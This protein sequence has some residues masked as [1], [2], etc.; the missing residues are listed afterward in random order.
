MRVLQTNPTPI[1]LGYFLDV[2]KIIYLNIWVLQKR[3]GKNINPS[4]PSNE[5]ENGMG[6]FIHNVFATLNF[7]KPSHLKSI[8]HHNIFTFKSRSI[9]A[10]YLLYFN[11]FLNCYDIHLLLI[12]LVDTFHWFLSFFP[13]C[14]ILKKPMVNVFFSFFSSSISSSFTN[15]SFT[16]TRP[17]NTQIFC[18]K[19]VQKKRSLNFPNNGASQWLTVTIAKKLQA[20]SSTKNY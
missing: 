6:F 15:T 20:S 18:Q 2:K 17:K 11:F 4:P 10:N 13:R 3:M 19:L 9:N 8:I 12:M 7:L 16:K 14:A 1:I 5:N